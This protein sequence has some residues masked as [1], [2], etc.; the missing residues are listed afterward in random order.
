MDDC[1]LAGLVRNRSIVV[2]YDP[3][4]PGINTIWVP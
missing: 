1:A 2:L 4:K 3:D